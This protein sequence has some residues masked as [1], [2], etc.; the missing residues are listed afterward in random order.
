M[1]RKTTRILILCPSPEGTAA[2]QRLKY[3]QYL[4]FL[5]KEGYQFTISAFQTKRFWKIIHQPGRIIEK[6][7]WTVI[8]YFKR[9]Y[10]L[11][12]C[13]FYDA[14]F[15]TIWAT[16]L[17]FPVYERLLFGFHKK[18]IYDLDDMMF[19]DKVEH[20]KENFVQ[21]LKGKKKPLVLMRHATYVIVCTPKLE[22]IALSINKHKKVIDIS[23]TFDTDRFTPVS[24]YEPKV[25]TTI[26]WTG[27]HSSLVFLESLQ[28]VLAAV[29]KRRKI[30]LLVIANKQ[31]N[32]CDVPTEFLYWK[33]QT[34]VTDLHQ[35]D[36][37]L[38]PIPASQWSLG[39]SSLKALTYMA[40]AIPFVATAY[41]TN[42]RIMQHGVQGYMALTN[43]E[44]IECII[45]LIDDVELRKQMGLAGRKTVEALYSVN[46][47]FSKYLE[48]F[49]TVAP[50][51]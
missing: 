30:R 50:T 23:A 13:P 27:T 4:P 31:Y 48:V 20:V 39:K 1:S 3:E 17:G 25:I 34:E 14:V 42:F 46:A 5:Q 47:N 43:E 24:S 28:P 49:K 38:Y 10:D 22:E 44:W 36:I 29:S 21:K 2:A 35:F 16:P 18:V 9:I 8:G 15:V 19:L 40:I 6:I 26:G 51:K 7:F 45:K 33:E 32:M 41:G 12:R 11:F 37:G